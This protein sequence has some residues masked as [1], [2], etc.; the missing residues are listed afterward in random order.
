MLFSVFS[1]PKGAKR[2][3][4]VFVAARQVVAD[5]WIRQAA[6]QIKQYAAATGILLFQFL[7]AEAIAGTSLSVKSAQ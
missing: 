7:T 5:G 6:H 4:G 2:L 1:S 3:T